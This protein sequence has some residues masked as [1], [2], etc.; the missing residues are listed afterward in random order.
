LS[1]NGAGHLWSIDLPHPFAPELHGET[2]AAIPGR[3]HQRWT[4]VQGSSRRR[5]PPLLAELGNIDLF[6]HCLLYTSRC[7]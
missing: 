4:Y 2:A 6:V 3:Q 5:L 1:L 7:V